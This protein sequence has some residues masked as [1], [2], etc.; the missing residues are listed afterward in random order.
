ME[1]IGQKTALTSSEEA[2]FTT[3]LEVE[4]GENETEKIFDS[5][6]DQM[7]A[8]ET[9]YENMLEELLEEDSHASLISYVHQNQFDSEIEAEETADTLSDHTLFPT[10]TMK[11]D[12]LSEDSR[13]VQSNFLQ[14]SVPIAEEMIELADPRIVTEESNFVNLEESG[15]AETGLQSLLDETTPDSS[16]AVL[17]KFLHQVEYA[18]D[19]DEL[20]EDGLQTVLKQNSEKA[21]TSE[22]AVEIPRSSLHTIMH[23]TS[24][25]TVLPEEVLPEEAV[26]QTVNEIKSD[27]HKT[28]NQTVLP[29]EAVVQTVN[30]IK[31]EMNNNLVRQIQN[32]EDF[33]ASNQK[34][35]GE[36]QTFNHKNEMPPVSS[37]LISENSQDAETSIGDPAKNLF[38]GS[39]MSKEQLKASESLQVV[40]NI[41]AHEGSQT[42]ASINDMEEFAAE[43]KSKVS[44]G[45]QISEKDKS[46]SE[47]QSLIRPKASDVAKLTERFKVSEDLQG[48][49]K[50]KVSEDLLAKEIFKSPD[51]LK[52][53]VK[54]KEIFQTTGTETTK[55]SPEK[56]SVV[57]INQFRT[58]ASKET[59][60]SGN[61]N[62]GIEPV[63]STGISA[64]SET[65][66]TSIYKTPDS[67]NTLADSL[68]NV[69]L[70]FDIQQLASRV[71]IMRGNGVE[72]MTLRLH[73]EE[74][75]HITLK[76]R[77]SGGDLLIDM[78]VDNPLAK[79]IVESGFD[80][81]RSR[82][83]DQE[84][85]YKDL[86]LNV[87][88][89]Q[90]DS[91]FGSDRQYE[92]FEDELFSSQRGKEQEISTVEETPLERHRT[93]S[94][95]NL[96]V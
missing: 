69:D 6:L 52:E 22:E 23:K 78:R 57:P 17:Q 4:S 82:F 3:D 95:L 25:Q 84:F 8:E 9:D 93:D 1:P 72:E 18:S 86:A 65:S 51:E 13:H 88:I 96:Y 67:M 29:E 77:Q 56:L 10:E 34:T 47:S 46:A 58:L 87:D 90:K 75:G 28:I 50:G 27:N 31:S 73:P 24:N 20:S 15:I 32:H 26:V 45:L 2:I 59:K 62:S 37:H 55:V 11:P 76:V 44:D 54:A 38:T 14:K 7:L 35:A 42:K 64:S 19:E 83:L 53:T 89:N 61:S 40:E 36:T 79:Q 68:K 49:A 12:L 81:L 5:T 30:E 41:K 71:R 80:S 66:G 74:L 33:V 94:G 91:Q 21:F 43:A 85:A 39:S 60:L 70:P 48:Q 63:I 92:E 16:N